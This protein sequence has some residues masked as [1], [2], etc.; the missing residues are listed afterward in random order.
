MVFGLAVYGA[1][2]SLWPAILVHAIPDTM[3]VLRAYHGT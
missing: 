3:T 1:K 2:G